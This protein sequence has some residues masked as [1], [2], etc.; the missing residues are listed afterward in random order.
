[1]VLSTMGGCFAPTHK[2][3]DTH[4]SG[5]ATAD[6]TSG[7]VDGGDG[8]SAASGC[9]AAV[10]ILTADGE[11]TGFVRCSDGAIN[12]AQALGTAPDI[13]DPRCAGD[14]DVVA[15]TADD[16]C[17]AR[18]HGAC[19]SVQADWGSECACVYAC[20][21]DEDCEDGQICLPPGV[22]PGGG[23]HSRCVSAACAQDADCE[24]GECGASAFD[25]GC[26]PSW[27]VACR[28]PADTCRVD[29]E[30]DE[31]DTCAIL[32]GLGPFSCRQQDCDIGRPLRVAGEVRVAGRGLGD[33]W[34]RSQTPLG[35]HPGLAEHWLG[36]ALLEHASVASFAQFVLELLALGAP[37][38]LVAAA[39]RAMQ[40]EIAHAR[41]AFGL[42]V[43]FGAPHATP[44]RLD[45]TGLT[46]R[47]GPA[48]FLDALV[49]EACV[50]ETFGAAEAAVAAAACPTPAVREVLQ[51][52]ARDEAQHAA[53]AWRT[54]AWMLREVV[55]DQRPRVG[56]RL[57]QAV[58]AAVAAPSRCAQPHGGVLSGAT[59]E[60]LRREV[61]E[62]VIAPA[63]RAATVAPE[64][65]VSGSVRVG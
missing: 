26:G 27:S 21:R 29:T 35:D 40:D 39:Q 44:G 2:D 61:A 28:S 36:I 64:K 24:S 34:S 48:A 57:E 54:L 33:R 42:A 13:P 58:A 17:T 19:L 3:D 16:D 30:C 52:V 32:P 65:I 6:G 22:L 59:L 9:G 55:P 50:G 43:A 10:P 47:T 15:C 23:D 60:S 45:L 7:V 11:E 37:P 56:Q 41:L 38:P 18:D 51:R 12:R 1:M 20:E 8:S 49:S 53:L 25:D 14:E 4:G 46:L 63:W 5:A 31:G 62:R